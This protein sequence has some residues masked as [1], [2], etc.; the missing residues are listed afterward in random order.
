MDPELIK[1][2]QQIK[3]FLV[4]GI[5]TQKEFGDQKKKLMVM[6]PVVRSAPLPTHD[7]P[8]SPVSKPLKGVSDSESRDVN[9]RHRWGYRTG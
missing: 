9:G 3:E 1:G 2:L 5:F 4:Q 6:Y 8:Q 7:V